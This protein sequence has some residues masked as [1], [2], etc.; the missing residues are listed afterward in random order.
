MKEQAQLSHR[1]P[2]IAG[3]NRRA[4]L[5]LVQGAVRGADAAAGAQ[6]P[7]DAAPQAA[8]AVVAR[9]RVVLRNVGALEL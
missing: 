1:S 7:E 3:R 2:T 4:I 9:A 8:R 5:H 6:V